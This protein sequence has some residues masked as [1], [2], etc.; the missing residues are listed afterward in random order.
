MNSK[1]VLFIF[2]C[3]MTFKFTFLGEIYVSELISIFICLTLFKKN[4]YLIKD[5][6]SIFFLLTFVFLFSQVISDLYMNTPSK[7]FLR[8]WANILFFI[9]NTTAILI[10]IKNRFENIYIFSI[11]LVSGILLTFF[12]NP[13]IYAQG[14]QYWKFGIGYGFTFLIALITTKI[15]FTK[16][17]LKIIIFFILCAVNFYMGFRSLAGVCFLVFLLLFINKFNFVKIFFKNSKPD[18]Y[19]III[20]FF[21]ILLFVYLLNY[22][23]TFLATNNYLG[24]IE[25]LRFR[26]QSGFFGILVGGRQELLMYFYTIS[27]SPL[28]GYGSWPNNPFYD[29]LL[30]DLLV[31][32]GYLNA[33]VHNY[34]GEKLPIHSH[35]FGA[36]VTAGIFG[37]FIWVWLL[38][39]IFK[40]LIIIF[41]N[42]NN[43]LAYF[44]LVCIWFSWDIFFSTFKGDGRFYGAYFVY[45]IL[46]MNNNKNFY[47]R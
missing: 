27:K 19:K 6:L 43:W 36:W 37:T 17:N 40:A 8:G 33:I 46:F 22:I 28:I 30:S 10:V 29:E 13:N 7:D 3:L 45:L 4:F 41:K 44:T 39:K 31:K 16:Q 32:Y 12:I 5:Y 15:S 34:S 20:L 11:G 21:I 47:E 23:Y 1:L 25:A 18:S 14:G 24:D 9:I 2:P 38:I 42:N 26:N 35:I